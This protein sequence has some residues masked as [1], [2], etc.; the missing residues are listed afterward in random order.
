MLTK[1]DPDFET[2]IP[3]SFRLGQGYIV[4]PKIVRRISQCEIKLQTMQGL[5]RG[6]GRHQPSFA[7]QHRIVRFVHKPQGRLGSVHRHESVEGKDKVRSLYW[8]V[9]YK[10]Y[11]IVLRL[12]DACQIFISTFLQNRDLSVV[13]VDV[14]DGAVFPAYSHFPTRDGGLGR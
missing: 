2:V 4:D 13:W 14:V 8:I 9:Q 1:P 10:A 11:I 12:N 7:V 5:S 6:F 3:F